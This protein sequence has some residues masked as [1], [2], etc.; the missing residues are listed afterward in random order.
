[1]STSSGIYFNREINFEGKTWKKRYKELLA[2][3]DTPAHVKIGSIW[4]KMLTDFRCHNQEI[5]LDCLKSLGVNVDDSDAVD[6]LQDIISKICSQEVVLEP[7]DGMCSGVF[8]IKDTT[9]RPIAVF[10]VGRKRAVVEM[11]V[12]KVAYACGLQNFVVPGMFC[13]LKNPPIPGQ[14]QPVTV[15]ED[16]DDQ[17]E[18]P[19]EKDPIDDTTVP[20]VEELWSG[21][22]KEF[23]A[24]QTNQ[25]EDGYYFVGILE[26]FVDKIPDSRAKDSDEY[27]NDFVNM[28]V[29]L[30]LTIARDCKDV[31]VMSS[32]R[33]PS[34]RMV[35]NMIVDIA[36]CFPEQ[37]VTALHE[38]KEVLCQE[39]SE[40]MISSVATT[41]LPILR[42]AEENRFLDRKFSPEQIT[43][44]RERI[45]QPSVL[46]NIM[47]TLL[48]Q[49]ADFCDQA[50]EEAYC[51]FLS[52][53][54]DEEDLVE[55]TR[56][57][58]DENQR[59]DDRERV[60]MEQ[61]ESCVDTFDDGNCRVRI[62]KPR[63]ELFLERQSTQKPPNE[64]LSVNET[65]SATQVS[66]FAQRYMC[67]TDYL[68][69]AQ[70]GEVSLQDMVFHMD[71]LFAVQVRTMREM[72]QKS[73]Q[74]RRDIASQSPFSFVGT[75]PLPINVST[76]PVLTQAGHDTLSPPSITPLSEQERANF[77]WFCSLSRRTPTFKRRDSL[78][79]RIAS[80]VDSTFGQKN[81][82]SADKESYS[83]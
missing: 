53:E 49:T 56:D 19:K 81:P 12:R 42:V 17:Q 58:V 37:I 40:K 65:L 27:F 1:M 6:D 44:L 82:A 62:A 39:V 78:E 20:I 71:P 48:S 7:L 70:V 3:K 46:T 77:S 9:D 36:E 21:G 54:K 33:L 31:D 23:C 61:E 45:C 14:T 63:Q 47:R 13:A 43:N 75:R 41:N 18:I 76:S 59:V 10:K 79:V 55:V 22:E 66:T 83:R 64:T 2:T 50:A 32:G 4:Q 80:A 72:Q 26:P 29:V 24:H 38:E 68:N 15:D 25:D 11:L 8:L 16:T 60:E 57:C 30:V 67:L 52:E 5:A 74:I 34:G 73:P 35:H 51:E 28:A 69:H